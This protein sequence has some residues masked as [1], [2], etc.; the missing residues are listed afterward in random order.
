MTAERRGWS[1]DNGKEVS[2]GDYV[3]GTRWGDGEGWDPWFVGFFHGRDAGRWIVTDGK[4]YR[5]RARRVEPITREEGDYILAR[6]KYIEEVG[7]PLYKLL[8]E[9]R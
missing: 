8:E 6:A 9:L 1:L 4:D 5:F 7:Y 2:E 3:L